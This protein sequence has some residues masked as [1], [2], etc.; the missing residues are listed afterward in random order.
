MRY[1]CFLSLDV[2][3]TEFLKQFVVRYGIQWECSNGNIT[4]KQSDNN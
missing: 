3:G 2:G 1:L 4:F